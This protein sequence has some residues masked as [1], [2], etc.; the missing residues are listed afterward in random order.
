V[1]L[2]IVQII[3]ALDAGG[4]ERT[5]VEITRA[6]IKAGGQAL[7][8]T[9]GGR[10]EDEVIAVGGSIAHLPVHSKNPYVVWRN[11]GRIAKIAKD[12]DADLL[13]ARSRAPA[14][15]TKAACQR[16]SLPFVTTYHGTYNA[17]SA[18]KRYYNSIMAA[19][20][21]VIA[22]SGFIARRIL[23]EHAIEESR[24]TVIPRGVAP[25][26]FDIPMTM[27]TAGSTIPGTTLKINRAPNEPM[28]VLPGRLTRWKGQESAIDAVTRLH[29]EGHK[30]HLVLAGDAQGR[31]HYVEAL[32]HQVARAGLEGYVHF[33]GHVEDM[34]A[35][36]GGA[37][38]VLSASIEPEAFGRVA[39]EGQ[40]SARLTVAAA[41]GGALETVLDGQTGFHFQP[42]NAEDLADVLKK[43]L[44]LD[45]DTHQ[46]IRTTARK[47]TL[48][49]YSRKAMCAKTLGLY[50]HLICMRK[51]N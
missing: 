3:P 12:F 28:I 25:V 20:D 50:R 11:V 17:R 1:S 2:K 46:H 47:H 44:R 26:Y 16:L 39:V 22:N 21:A 27:D 37:D 6:V 24:L 4:A 30:A 43:A 7:C 10:L 38:I 41:H 45:T 34:A 33:C 8:I 48:A 14:W 51:G 31:D 36:Y 40:A 5:V 9:A 18:P 42:A 35:L 19:G 23:D 32:H 15:S 29:Q 49:H 13:H